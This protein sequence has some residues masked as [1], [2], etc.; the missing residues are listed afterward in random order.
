MQVYYISAFLFN[1]FKNLVWNSAFFLFSPFLFSC[2]K[3]LCNKFIHKKETEREK[4]KP[5]NLWMYI[6]IIPLLITFETIFSFLEPIYH[7]KTMYILIRLLSL[8]WASVLIAII[9]INEKWLERVKTF[10]PQITL[11]M[12]RRHKKIAF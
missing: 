4:K 7:F 3:K 12:P 9:M 2:L 1:I 6:Y 8:K 10:Q 5:K 11:N